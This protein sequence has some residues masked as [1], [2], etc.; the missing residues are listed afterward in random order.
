MKN[1]YLLTLNII[2]LISFYHYAGEMDVL[3]FE[4]E[5]FGW[6]INLS[7]IFNLIILLY[8]PVKENFFIK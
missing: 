8:Y 3:N 5:T 6:T 1:N 4:K 7:L 2:A